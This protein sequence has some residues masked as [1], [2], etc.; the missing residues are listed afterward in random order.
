MHR[1]AP[2]DERYINVGFCIIFYALFYQI[3]IFNI[4]AVKPMFYI[5]K[6]SAVIFLLALSTLGH[7]YVRNCLSDLVVPLKISN[8]IKL[9]SV[10]D[11]CLFLFIFLFFIS[12]LI[13]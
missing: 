5:I 11:A 13:V 2:A 4:V 3:F 8:Y 7:H 9:L 1:S 6:L 12:I 10:E